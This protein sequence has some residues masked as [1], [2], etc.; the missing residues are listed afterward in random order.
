MMLD[1]KTCFGTNSANSKYLML[2]NN[3]VQPNIYKLF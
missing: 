1:M 3:F 2:L